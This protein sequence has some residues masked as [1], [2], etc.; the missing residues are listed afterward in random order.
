MAILVIED[1]TEVRGCL[2]MMLHSEGFTVE[3]AGDGEEALAY[4][5]THS[6]PSLILLD[7]TMPTMDG[8]EFRRQQL[9]DPRLAKIPVIVLTGRRE[10]AKLARELGVVEVLSKPVNLE[11]L[12]HV[13]QNRATTVPRS[14]H[15]LRGALRSQR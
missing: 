12:I 6:T 15:F 14:E 10:V 11:E 1:D 9:A 8:R 2:S 7:L 3:A 13:V 5:R 4:L